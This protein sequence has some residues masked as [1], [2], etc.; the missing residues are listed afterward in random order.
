MSRRDLIEKLDPLPARPFDGVVFRS[1][2]SSYAALSGEGARVKGGRWNPPNSF[3]VI[4]TALDEET[5]A[6]EIGRSARKL[7]LQPT[8]LL[9][10]ELT[11][12]NATLSRVLDLAD[13]DIQRSSGL[14]LTVITDDDIRI[15]QAVGDAAHYL[16]FEA[17]L[18][19]S[20]AGGTRNLSIFVNRLQA[21][22]RLDIVATTTIDTK[23]FALLMA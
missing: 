20:A 3:P 4:Y 17:I 14:T 7:G 8:D 19:P 1:H 2:S 23:A 13:Q 10:R 22:S 16:G 5:V 15:C 18:A 21:S 11:K 12:V 9:P 6:K